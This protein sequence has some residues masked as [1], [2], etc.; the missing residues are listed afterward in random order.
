M[1]LVAGTTLA[2]MQAGSFAMKYVVAIEG[3]PYLLTDAAPAAAVAAWTGT[4]WTQA[5]PG[6]L[7]ELD[8]NQT[9]DP[10]NPLQGGGTCTLRVQPD[11]TDRLGIDMA[12]RNAGA[13][14]VLSSTLTRS[15]TSDV[16]K[17]ADDFPAATAEAYVGTECFEYS[18]KTS[19]SFSISKRGK[20]S[21]FAAGGTGAPRFAE[22]HRVGTNGDGVMLEPVISQYPR[23]WKGKWVGVWVHKTD[24]TNLNSK[25]DAQLVFAGV[26]DEPR[27]DAETGYTCILCTSVL[28]MFKNGTLGR[29]FFNATAAVGRYIQAGATFRMYDFVQSTGSTKTANDLVCVASGASGANQINAGYYGLADI[30]NVI[31]TWLG[32]E[33]SAARLNG[34]YYWINTPEPSNGGDRTVMHYECTST[35]S[36]VCHWVLDFPDASWQQTLGLSTPQMIGDG[37]TNTGHVS[38][39]ESGPTIAGVFQLG[40]G[41]SVTLNLT[42]SVGTFQDQYA[43]LPPGIKS[44]LPSGGGGLQWGVFMFNEK[45]LIVGAYDGAL[46]LSNVYAIASPINAGFPDPNSLLSYQVPQGDGAATVRQIFIFN[47]PT[48]TLLNRFVFSTGTNGYNDSTYDVNPYGFGLGIPAGLLPNFLTSSATMVGANV[49]ALITIDKPTKFADLFTADLVLRRTHVIWKNGGVQLSSWSTPVVS[50]GTTILNEANKAEPAGNQVNHATPSVEDST[51]LK[52]TV[53]INWNRDITT[54]GANKES[55]AATLTIE[56]GVSLD[57]QGGQGSLATLNARNSYDQ[58]G[59][60]GGIQQLLPGFVAWFPYFSRPIIKI[61]RSVNQ[62]FFEIAPGD[63]VSVSD[64]RVRDPATGKRKITARPGLVVRAR[65]QLGGPVPGKPGETTPQSVEVDVVFL[66][67]NRVAAYAPAAEVDDT[68][69]AGGFSAGYNSGTSTL[70]C[71]AHKHSESSE[72]ADAANFFASDKILIVEIDPAGGGVPISWTRTIQSVSSNDITLTAGLSSPAWDNT[73]KYRVTYDAFSVDQAAQ[74]AKTFQAGTDATVQQLVPAFEYGMTTS[75]ILATSL[76]HTTLPELPAA[77]SWGPDVGK[78]RDT[79]YEK[80]LSLLL[81]NLVD[82]KT[83]RQSPMMTIGVESNTTYSSG[84]GWQLLYLA[85]IY[86]SQMESNLATVI[87]YL[88]VAP[89][90]RSSDGT[91]TNI[92]VSLTPYRPT[93]TS[94]NDVTIKAPAVSTSWST[95]STTWTTGTEAGLPLYVLNGFTSGWLLI[96]GKLK[97][98]TRG[99][100]QCI[101]RERVAQ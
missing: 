10:W 83:A 27:D 93:D 82:H 68:A 20:Y 92:R 64:N 86:V 2:A 9:I 14:T 80:A 40:S 50:G 58:Y 6:L 36:S 70:R 69:G 62:C 99:L 7:V 76:D 24:G 54:T 48:S 12:K 38:I 15:A 55:Y 4:D 18:A 63:I 49:D 13:E 100:A 43:T 28:D 16:V 88:Y 23:S 22:W 21:P 66:A 79:G 96:E 67:V 65:S 77:I 101:E 45:F 97:C 90:F 32:S 73:K 84:N 87:R 72:S 94:R 35:G 52:N 46:T 56:D 51:W 60:G 81:D 5:L 98:E 89:W 85:P 59:L 31:N 91:A 25:A 19:T 30:C 3:Y 1:T 26:I 34:V 47:G 78:P 61:T 95:S 41:F 53:K 71:Y 17:R 37:T 8:R 11:P 33:I 44:I 57:D 39:S 42:S 29:D 74:Q 75:A